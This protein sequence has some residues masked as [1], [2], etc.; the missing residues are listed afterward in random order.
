MT[1]DSILSE[2]EI[3][4]LGLVAE[5]LTNRE[6]AQRLS[7][8]HNTVKVHLRNVFEKISVSSRTEATV[9]AIEHRI[10]D[11]PGGIDQTDAATDKKV[12]GFIRNYIW[13]WVIFAVL[14]VL[15]MIIFISNLSTP[16]TTDLIETVETAERWQE[17]TPL[18]ESRKDMAVVAYSGDLF[19]IG[20]ESPEGVSGVG[21]RYLLGEDKW[22]SIADKPT[23]VSNVNAVVIGEKI[24]VPGGEDDNGKPTDILEIYNPRQ[25]AWEI[26]VPLPEALSNYA[27]A[28]LEGKMYL[29]GGWD[30]KNYSNNV[31]IFNP[32][33][34]EWDSGQKMEEGLAGLRATTLTDKI[35]VF[36]GR[37][38]KGVT[39]E[40]KL[41]YP[42]RDL[43]GEKQWEKFEALPQGRYQFGVAST[44][45][46]IYLVGGILSNERSKSFV[47]SVYVFYDKNWKP[48]SSVQN[49]NGRSI[50]MLISNSNLYVFN[51]EEQNNETSLWVLRTLFFD[52]FIPFIP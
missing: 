12:H 43:H 34:N 7:I 51:N 1:G 15:G 47:N 33:N 9:Y 27:L 31:W 35:V 13:V 23:P 24:F 50:S 21:F 37:N 25:D 28:D 40:G 29:F 2:R 41:F 38:E 30:G 46:S 20:G 6:I 8:S 36:G 22:T 16:K 42:A 32:T 17:L 45:D 48:L 4:I 10:V 18:P 44:L 14:I 26:G 52:I 11:M 5:G 49:F 3:E 39:S 19:A